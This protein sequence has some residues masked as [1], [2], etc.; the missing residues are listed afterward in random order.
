MLL[1]AAV[2]DAK[3]C[4]YSSRCSGVIPSASRFRA[5]AVFAGPPVFILPAGATTTSMSKRLRDKG[6]AII[7]ITHKHVAD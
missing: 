5:A 7:F 1:R 3:V 2:N 6:V 4:P